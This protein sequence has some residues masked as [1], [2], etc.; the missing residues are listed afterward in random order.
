MNK[1]KRKCNNHGMIFFPYFKKQMRALVDVGKCLLCSINFIITMELTMMQQCCSN[2]DDR[3]EELGLVK[4]M[5]KEK[6]GGLG[7]YVIMSNGM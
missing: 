2:I 4:M 3:E 7:M 5:T 6:G 1:E